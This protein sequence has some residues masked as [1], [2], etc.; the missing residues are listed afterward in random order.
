MPNRICAGIVT[1]NPDIPILKRNISSLNSQVN[2][3]IIF[4]NG[5]MNYKEIINIQEKNSNTS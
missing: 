5:S 4:D 1:Y 2:L 3:I